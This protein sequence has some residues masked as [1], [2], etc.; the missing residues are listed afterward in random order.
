MDIY[1]AGSNG[2]RDLIEL[3]IKGII[4]MDIYLAGENGK[5]RILTAFIGGG[6]NI[7]D[8]TPEQ[9]INYGHL[10]CRRRVRQPFRRMEK[11]NRKIEGGAERYGLVFKRYWRMSIRQ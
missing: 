5:S 8:V 10:S 3:A 2:R 11:S 6:Y 7:Y 1:L 9:I 4:F